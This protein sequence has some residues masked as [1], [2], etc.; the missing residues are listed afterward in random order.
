MLN[1]NLKNCMTVLFSAFY[2][3][4][5][6]PVSDL[7]TWSS[8][9]ITII[10]QCLFAARTCRWWKLNVKP[11]Q[12]DLQRL[13]A[14]QFTCRAIRLAVQNE[15]VCGLFFKS[16]LALVCRPIVIE[17]NSVDLWFTSERKTCVFHGILCMKIF[18]YETYGSKIRF[19]NIY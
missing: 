18:V 16:Q 15:T 10:C 6:A 1:S 2:L 3:T 7:V 9:C 11:S 14:H 4:Y 12:P 19:F 5:A 17:R 8:T 13:Q